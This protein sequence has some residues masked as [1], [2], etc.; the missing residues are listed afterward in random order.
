MTG[1]GEGDF[2]RVPA[3]RH[4]KEQERPLRDSDLLPGTVPVLRGVLGGLQHP[5]R[6]DG[7]SQAEKKG[8][9]VTVVTNAERIRRMSEEAMAA[10]IM[11]PDECGLAEMICDKRDLRNCYECCLSWLKAERRRSEQNKND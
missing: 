2:Q 11:C 5:V 3:L 6:V 8:G 7:R 9:G 4:R 10:V 1:D